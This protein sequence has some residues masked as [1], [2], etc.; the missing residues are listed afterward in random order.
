MALKND[1][2]YKAIDF[3]KESLKR[4]LA[5]ETFWSFGLQN[6]FKIPLTTYLKYVPNALS[7]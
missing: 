6:V 5:F 3:N 2:F 4:G 1:N 7:L